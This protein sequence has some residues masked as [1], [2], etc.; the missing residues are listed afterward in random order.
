M[1]PDNLVTGNERLAGFKDLQAAQEWLLEN[2]TGRLIRMNDTR[3]TKEEEEC[4]R[5]ECIRSKTELERLKNQIG[6]SRGLDSVE[7]TNQQ[8]RTICDS[9]T[10]T[11][12][13]ERA[14]FHQ[15]RGI[16]DRFRKDY[17]TVVAAKLIEIENKNSDRVPDDCSAKNSTTRGEERVDDPS[18]TTKKRRSSVEA[19]T[20]SP[21]RIRKVAVRSPS[22]MKGQQGSPRKDRISHR[23]GIVA[24][25]TPRIS[26]PTHLN[27][28]K[29]NP[30]NTP[31]SLRN[32]KS[33]SSAAL[34]TAN[35][36][37]YSDRK[38]RHH[39]SIWKDSPPPKK[40]K[41]P[42]NELFSIKPKQELP[43]KASNSRLSPTNNKVDQQRPGK[44]M[45]EE[46]LTYQELSTTEGS[47][48]ERSK[49]VGAVKGGGTSKD[50]KGKKKALDHEEAGSPPSSSSLSSL[51]SSP[52]HH[53]S[54]H[55]EN[56]NNGEEEE[57]PGQ[58]YLRKIHQKRLKTLASKKPKPSV[59]NINDQFEIDP[60]HNF[61][62]KHVFNET[63]VRGKENRKKMHGVGCDC[64]SGY[65][66]QVAKDLGGSTTNSNHQQEISRHRHFNPPPQTPPG[67]WQMGFPDTQH[68]EEINR[69]AVENNKNK[70]KKI[71]VQA[72]NGIGPYKFKDA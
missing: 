22:P 15:D 69:K 37:R 18:S 63:G 6:G 44:D 36:I 14:Q 28:M 32:P 25:K 46:R 55:E 62:V 1:E 59:D 40:N 39:Q 48:D 27:K 53:H 7:L 33:S 57:F 23:V 49:K 52:N 10:Q 67:Y 61:G 21:S 2:P 45:E 12:E 70:F 58:L 68:V 60:N 71:Q 56:N 30:L 3:S 47:S 66:E 42:S 29:R 16:W 8:L 72:K 20:K 64:C 11:L 4:I 26:H 5:P 51:P 13:S 43:P 17:A 65:Y 38:A 24:N 34:P 41:A 50:V 19:A 9:L 35:W 31:Q 54:S